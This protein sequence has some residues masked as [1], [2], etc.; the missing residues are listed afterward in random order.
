M[1]GKNP[2][3]VKLCDI[4]AG[5]SMIDYSKDTIFVLDDR[6]PRFDPKRGTL[7]RPGHAGYED[8]PDVDWNL[9]E[10]LHNKSI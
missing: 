10:K 5:K 2:N 3:I 7:V 6:P 8:L 1:S 9:V 4:P